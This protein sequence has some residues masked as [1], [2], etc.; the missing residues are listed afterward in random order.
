VLFLPLFRQKVSGVSET[1]VLLFLEEF[2]EEAGVQRWFFGGVN[3][4][5]CVASAVFKTP[6]L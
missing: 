2:L 1:V 6:L 4:V 5:G 3:V